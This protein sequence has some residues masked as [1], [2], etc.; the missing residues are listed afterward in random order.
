[1]YTLKQDN[2]LIITFFI[3]RKEK[4][5]KEKKSISPIFL[6]VLNSEYI[7]DKGKSDMDIIYYFTNTLKKII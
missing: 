2:I 4:I 7:I 6:Y 3:Y 1:M 5:K